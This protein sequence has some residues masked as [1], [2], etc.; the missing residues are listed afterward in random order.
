VVVI[1]IVAVI[2]G[3]GTLLAVTCH[4]RADHGPLV[5]A[6][7][8]AGRALG[9]TVT[10]A[11]DGTF[12]LDALV[13]GQTVHLGYQLV[14][15]C[16]YKPEIFAEVSVNDHASQL[17]VHPRDAHPQAEQAHELDDTPSGDDLFDD[18][19]HVR[20]APRHPGRQVLPPEAQ[21][22]MLETGPISIRVANGHLR[23]RRADASMIDA[24]TIL[25]I[26]RIAG[27]SARAYV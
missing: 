10:R 19:Y 23:V 9:G 26:A 1:A 4:M 13:A 5:D 12:Q 7:R 3:L 25:N 8:R 20:S 11:P 16:G 27:L 14:F 18:A 22:L 24:P 17:D 21:R 6:L 15:S 2:L